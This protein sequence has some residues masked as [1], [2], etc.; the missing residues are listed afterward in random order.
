MVATLSENQLFGELAVLTNVPRTATLRA[1]GRL[2]ALRITKEVFLQ[3]VTENPEVA[4]DVMRQLS[5]KLTLS[6]RQVEALQ[7][8]LHRGESARPD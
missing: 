8:E 1:S 6:H 5:E 7:S 3:L 2:E 4:L